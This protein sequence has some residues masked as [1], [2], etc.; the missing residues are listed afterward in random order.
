MSVMLR[1][2][3]SAGSTSTNPPLRV[4]TVPPSTTFQPWIPSSPISPRIPLSSIATT[5]ALPELADASASLG[6]IDTTTMVGLVQDKPKASVDFGTSSC[7]APLNIQA[8]SDSPCVE[9][10]S[11]IPGA[12]CTSQCEEGFAPSVTTMTCVNGT[13]VPHLF[14]CTP[15]FPGSATVPHGATPRE[16][17]PH[18]TGQSPTTAK[19]VTM[20]TLCGSLQFK[21]SGTKCKH[22]LVEVSTKGALQE[23]FEQLRT[24]FSLDVAVG[25]F[26]SWSNDAPICVPDSASPSGSDSLIHRALHES[27]FWTPSSSW[28]AMYTLVVAKTDMDTFLREAIQLEASVGTLADSLQRQ[29]ANPEVVPTIDGVSF[30]PLTRVTSTPAEM[31]L[32]SQSKPEIHW[33][34]I[35]LAALALGILVLTCTICRG[36]SSK[37]RRG[38]Q[39]S[40]I[41]ED[42]PAPFAACLCCGKLLCSY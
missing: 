24:P 22:Q 9:G 11:I 18:A 12:S 19:H 10:L 31:L 21:E 38:A 27:S 32:N 14:M 2:W 29:F 5:S 33:S 1:P 42:T 16:G 23:I 26:S 25:Q 40:E 36:L 30:A 13:F 20:A 34:Y 3:E 6:S 41:R 15:M 39:Y 17:D 7:M 28:W 8:V 4:W 35:L 37:K